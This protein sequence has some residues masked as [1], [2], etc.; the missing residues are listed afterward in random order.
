MIDTMLPTHAGH[1]FYFSTQV[2]KIK[3]ETFC[4]I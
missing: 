1:V 2:P 3:E 4:K